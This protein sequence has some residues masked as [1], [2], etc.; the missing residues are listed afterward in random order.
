MAIRPY[1]NHANLIRA[2]TM[3]LN[4]PILDRLAGCKSILIAGAGGGFDVFAGLPIYFALREAGCTVHLA[5][6]SFCDFMI[7]HIFSEPIPLHET[8]VLGARPPKDA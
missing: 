1:K 2:T 6:Y 4:L 8:L 3:Q 5:N 7:A